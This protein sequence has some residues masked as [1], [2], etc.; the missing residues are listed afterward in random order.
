MEGLLIA[1][2]VSLWVVVL[3]LAA[4]VFG[5]AR[6]VGVLL[7]RV[8]PAGALDTG[9]GLAPGQR[10]PPLRVTT[11]DGTLIDVDGERDDGRSRLFFFVSPTCPICDTLLPVARD[12][13]RAEGDWLDLVLASDGSDVDHA[14]FL[15]QKGATDLLY[16]V[17]EPLGRL[18]RVAQLPY[19]V[20]VDETGRVASMGLTNTR[21]HLESLIEAKR[22]G[23]PSIQSYLE[24]ADLPVAGARS[25]G[26]DAKSSGAV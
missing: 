8:A 4:V 22:S 25:G 21:E 13:A 12:L 24:R 5:L 16:V 6:Q 2:V 15:R 14:A 10:V 7:E 1:A 11:L 18:F 26:V 19:G 23:H 3:V 17:S 20:L 9:R